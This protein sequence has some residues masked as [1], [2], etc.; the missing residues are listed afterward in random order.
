M[1]TY[2]RLVAIFIVS[3]YIVERFIL[4]NLGW[5]EPVLFLFV[6]SLFLTVT[7]IMVKDKP[8]RNEKVYAVL[9]LILLVVPGF[10]FGIQSIL[11]NKL[12]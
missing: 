10:Y 3:W 8:T 7:I 11:S 12:F 1:Y 2:V 6:G 4:S 9:T 5:S